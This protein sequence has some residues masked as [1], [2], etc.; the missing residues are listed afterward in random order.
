MGSENFFNSQNRCTGAIK[1]DPFLNLSI[2][3]RILFP[4]NIKKSESINLF[5]STA[6]SCVFK[7]VN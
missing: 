2:L 3:L 7:V 5:G 4:K 1:N 6:R